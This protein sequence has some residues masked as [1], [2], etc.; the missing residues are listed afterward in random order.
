MLTIATPGSRA[1]DAAPG[2]LEQA[3]Q[4]GRC[5][6]SVIAVARQSLQQH[7]LL[8][9]RPVGLQTAKRH[10]DGN[11]RKTVR[12]YG[13]TERG[14]DFADVERVAHPPIRSP[15]DNVAGLREH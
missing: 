10:P 15:V 6:A 3:G 13:D 4:Q 12:S 1:G 8:S 9:H 7:L 11:C 14:H 5:A 2:R